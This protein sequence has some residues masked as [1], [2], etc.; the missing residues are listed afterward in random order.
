MR[1]AS[2][3]RLKPAKQPK[4]RSEVEP[5]VAGDHTPTLKLE[6]GYLRLESLQ[7]LGNGDFEVEGTLVFWRESVHFFLIKIKPEYLYGVPRSPCHLAL[8]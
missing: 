5:G 4:K 8:F 2:A 6:L 7:A 1:R 3:T